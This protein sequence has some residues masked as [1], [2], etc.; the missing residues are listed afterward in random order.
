MLVMVFMVVLWYNWL[1]VWTGLAWDLNFIA[2]CC[3]NGMANMNFP[4]ISQRVF[5]VV[6]LSIN[7]LP[8]HFNCKNTVY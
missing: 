2:R 1:V 8:G 5:W 7:G 6:C 4:T 3:N